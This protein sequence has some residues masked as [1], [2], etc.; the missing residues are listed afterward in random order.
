[1][2]GGMA[3]GQDTRTGTVAG[4]ECA[5]VPPHA[6]SVP[7]GGEAAR[8][9][10]H[11]L[12]HVLRRSLDAGATFVQDKGMSILSFTTSAISGQVGPPVSATPSLL[13][14]SV[15]EYFQPRTTYQVLA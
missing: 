4:C 15:P 8:A 12:P 10:P 14:A 6:S 3:D 1:M 7:R 9:A 5:C 11:D 13:R 2:Y